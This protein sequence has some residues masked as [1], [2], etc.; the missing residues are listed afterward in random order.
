ME[1]IE[2]AAGRQSNGQALD[3]HASQAQEFMI[4][5]HLAPSFREALRW[6]DSKDD[7]S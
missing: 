7:G 3:G 4:V 1:A 6:E 2:A 5:P